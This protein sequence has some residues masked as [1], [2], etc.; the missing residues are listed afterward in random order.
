MMEK[1]TGYL[2]VSSHAA[3]RPRGSAE[4]F[5]GPADKPVD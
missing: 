1:L 4:E 3:P 5:D 2:L